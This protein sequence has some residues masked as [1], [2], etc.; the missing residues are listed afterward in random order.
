MEKKHTF[1]P[2]RLLLIHKSLLKTQ[3]PLFLLRMFLK[4]R[5]RLPDRLAASSI[6]RWI[7][8]CKIVGRGLYRPPSFHV[9]Q[10][11]KCGRIVAVSESIYNTA[12]RSWQV[13]SSIHRL[14]T[15]IPR[16]RRIST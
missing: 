6:N 7:E 9:V 16:Q 13:Y 15:P 2:Q 4:G 11:T 14:Q 10:N 8:Y 1:K 3:L 12:R 5:K